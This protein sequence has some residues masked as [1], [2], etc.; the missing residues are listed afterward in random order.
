MPGSTFNFN[1]IVNKP[2]HH[3]SEKPMSWF[4]SE[5]IGLG[6][7]AIGIYEVQSPRC[8]EFLRSQTKR[9]QNIVKAVAFMIFLLFWIL[10]IFLFSWVVP[11]PHRDEPSL[12][13]STQTCI[14]ISSQNTSHSYSVSING[15]LG[16]YFFNNQVGIIF[17]RLNFQVMNKVYIFFHLFIWSLTVLI[18]L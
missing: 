5:A 6:T 12:S 2:V 16:I 4:F 15:L 10:F 13:F 8:T 14:L 9:T 11:Y 7:M 18:I 17:T 3:K 1:T